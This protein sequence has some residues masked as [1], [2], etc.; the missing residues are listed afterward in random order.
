M[1]NIP[2]EVRESQEKRRGRERKGYHDLPFHGDGEEDDEVEDE[3]GPEDRNVKHREQGQNAGDENGTC[4][5]VPAVE[6]QY[7]NILSVCDVG[8]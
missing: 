6:Q 2:G 7:L 5:R 4:G 3:D 1:V 8:M